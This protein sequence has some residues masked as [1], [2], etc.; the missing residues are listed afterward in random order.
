MSKFLWISFVSWN[1][2]NTL[3]NS[4]LCSLRFP[5]PFFHFSISPLFVFLPSFLP[6][7]NKVFIWQRPGN[8]KNPGEWFEKFY[9]RFLAFKINALKIMGE[10]IT[11]NSI[12]EPGWVPDEIGNIELNFHH[13]VTFKELNHRSSLQT[14]T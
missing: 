8:M 9:G 13:I 10:P 6:C 11:F 3:P 7:D 1:Y 4:K 14:K 5:S 12:F 2:P